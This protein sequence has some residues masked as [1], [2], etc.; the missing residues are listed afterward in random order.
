MKIRDARRRRVAL[1]DTRA[2]LESIVEKE[3]AKM[4]EADKVNGAEE[5]ES[6]LSVELTP[7]PRW[8]GT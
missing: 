4:D 7:L 8:V 2:S 1:S 6:E 5:G 3:K